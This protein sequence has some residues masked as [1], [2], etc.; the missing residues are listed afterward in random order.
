MCAFSAGFDALVNERANGWRWPRG[1]LRYQPAI[2]RELA[3]LTPRTYS[4]V[5]DGEA[6]RQRAVLLSISNLVSIGNGMK[7]TPEA[8]SD[9]G[10]LDLFLVS[11]LSR[12]AFL[13]IYPLVFSGRHTGHPVAGIERVREVAIDSPG[14]VSY[15][16]GERIG[17]LPA[18]VTVDPVA[19]QLWV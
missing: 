14:I 13:R 9:D 11:P 16:D 2:L 18:T 7:I 15:A 3:R 10:R 6:R 5:V 1:P 17:P 8:K 12:L 4:L 19:L